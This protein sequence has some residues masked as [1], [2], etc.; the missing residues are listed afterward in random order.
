MKKHNNENR[1]YNGVSI[2]NENLIG[3]KDTKEQKHLKY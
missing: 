1:A 2:R 3:V